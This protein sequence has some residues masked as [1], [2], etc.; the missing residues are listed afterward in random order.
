MLGILALLNY[1]LVGIVCA[2]VFLHD[3]SPLLRVWLG[4]SFGILLMM[5]LPVLAAFLV[6]FTLLAQAIAATLANLFAVAAIL[7]GHRHPHAVRPMEKA[8]RNMLIVLCCFV[9]PMTILMGYLQHTHTLREVDGRLHVGQSTY[10]DLCMHLSIVTGLRNAALPAEYIILPGSTL[11]YPFLTDGLSTSLYMLGVPL[12]L[13]FIVPGTLMSALVYAGYL[14]LAKEM[15]GKTSVA[16]LAAVLLFFNGGLG[17]LYNFDLS[18]N[19]L[20]KIQEI[21]TGYYK[22]PPNLPDLNLRWSNLVVDLLLPQRTFLGGWVLLL[23]ALYFAREAFM[24]K[25]RRMFLCAALFGAALP[26]VHTH[27]FLALALYSGSALVYAFVTDREKQ[28]RRALLIGSCLYLG[29]VLLCAV[30]QLVAFTLKQATSEGFIRFHYNWVNNINGQFVD[31]PPW[32]WLKNIGLPLLVMLFALLDFKKHHRMDLIGAS[33]IFLTANLIQFQPL[34]YDNNKLFYIWYLLMLPAAATWCVALFE[35]LSGSRA[36]V[37][38]AA[39]FI[40]GSTLSAALSMGREVIS[41]YPLFWESDVALAAYI[42]EETDPDAT[43][44]TAF[45]HNNPVYTL[46]GRKIVCGP[47]MF[48]GTHGLDYRRR[49]ADVSMFYGDPEDN[50]YILDLYDVDYI[51][52]T[53]QERSEFIVDEAALS[54]LF[55]VVYETDGV[56]LYAAEQ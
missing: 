41:D 17:F 23:P 42:E 49:M 37:L 18:G 8:D 25:E 29:L 35:K 10:G 55:P 2:R 20:S 28:A 44:M 48:L 53:W 56:T 1:L 38:L 52:V 15:S 39:L 5:W 3:K 24:Q 50:L 9:V 36:R 13:A 30:P 51:L 26:L 40:V 43:F 11:G 45:H 16:V 31:F 21:F 27:S 19:D 6:R 46:A 7:Y 4:L 32:F 34:D 47:P 14:L 33:L 22:T 12:R 54:N